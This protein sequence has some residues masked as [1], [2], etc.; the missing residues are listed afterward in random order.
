MQRYSLIHKN[1][2]REFILLKGTG[3]K[4]KRCTF[5]DYH[6]DSSTSPFE[7]NQKVLKQVTGTY[8]VLDIIN[9]GSAMELDPK[10]ID[11]IK[12]VV[13]QH[14]IH[15][16]WFEA[17][18]MYRNELNDFAKHFENTT[19][20]FR[21]GIETFDPNLRSKW[22]KGIPNTATPEDVAE[23]FQGVCLLC[24]TEGETKERILT[25][26]N[27]ARKHFEYFSI[28]LFCNNKTVVKRDNNLAQWF[29]AEVYPTLQDL[30]GIEV[31]INNTDLKV[32]A[33]SDNLN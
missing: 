16:L 19:V 25:D 9:S 31:L 23:H 14:N 29:I 32:G 12:Q 18:Y 17:H 22:R 11:M 27:I 5:C 28:N 2:P 33:S 1:L 6:E 13:K 26:I 3:C 4:W 21:C 10:T 24:C 15:T 7:I 8:G 20:K 30:N